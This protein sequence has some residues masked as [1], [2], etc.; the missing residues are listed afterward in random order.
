MCS[1]LIFSASPR[2]VAASSAA[3]KAG[4]VGGA[5]RATAE[6]AA[7][8]ATPTPTPAP[9]FLAD[10]EQIINT[11]GVVTGGVI[12]FWN[13]T[14]GGTCA[15]STDCFAAGTPASLTAQPTPSPGPA[16]SDVDFPNDLLFDP[17]GDLL[18]A[19][20]GS[21]SP[22]FGNFACV[23][24]SAVTT[25]TNNVTV[26][27][28]NGNTNTFDDPQFLA[29]GNDSKGTVALTNTS[30]GSGNTP[31][32]AEFA[33][34]NGVYAADP[35]HYILHSA[36]CCG[37]NFP[38]THQVVALPSASQ[39]P[40][41]FA[42]SITDTTQ[43]NTHVVFHVVFHHRDGSADTELSRNVPSDPGDPNL[44]DPFIDYDPH[45]DQ[46]AV[47]D[48]N[49]TNSHLTF[50]SVASRTKVAGP[51]TFYDDGSGNSNGVP[52]LIAVSSSGYVAVSYGVSV[53]PEVQIYDNSA[54]HGKLKDPA[55]G[56]TILDPI[57][58]DATTTKFGSDYVYGGTGVTNISTS[59][60]WI[61]GT[62]LMITLYSQHQ[63]VKSAANGMYI[64]DVT[65][66]GQ[67]QSG[68]DPLGRAY[69]KGPKQ[70]G[71]QH[72]TNVPLA[73]S[74]RPG[75]FT[76]ATTGNCNGDP[77]C[78]SSINSAI[79]SVHNVRPSPSARRARS[80]TKG[81]A[82]NQSPPPTT[83]TS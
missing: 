82:R 59:M 64:F 29:L 37:P 27:N 14:L 50:W 22:D 3:T 80:S 7:A 48:N 76:T 74:I 45:N 20:G 72:L 38:G 30:F 24:A 61:T 68:F 70:T 16:G 15:P 67:T 57:G 4:T 2:G 73:T 35:S 66:N 75:T 62:K 71:F 32:L 79:T 42:V 5:V 44:T 65:Q 63:H 53:G 46:I 58:M 21:G 77:N 11:S 69:G 43:A 34:V 10:A 41:T 12:D 56:T 25:G 83:A 81:R 33:P 39:P 31:D 13:I 18:I 26:L 60:R 17:V 8:V 36:Y 51:F 40:G 78:F 49:G 19:N 55:D 23:P 52:S 47:A 6:P 54:T 9:I 28:S 1:A